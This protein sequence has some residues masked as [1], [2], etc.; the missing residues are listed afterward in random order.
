[1]KK[2]FLT[3]ILTAAAAVLF[4]ADSA[5]KKEDLNNVR[6][7]ARNTCARSFSAKWDETEKAIVF[8]ADF[9]N[10]T[11]N[12][13]CYPTFKLRQ[14]EDISGATAIKYDIK[15]VKDS[16][17]VP[18]SH[19]VML[20]LKGQKIKYLKVENPTEEWKTVTVKFNETPEKL[21][22]AEHINIGM[23]SEEQILKYM[24]RNVELVK[25]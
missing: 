10:R 1:M 20:K 14:G 9:K 15:L 5:P 13:W 19:L 8:T 12:C 11:D 24:I 23:H 22:T 17:P 25:N 21:K 3:L 7:W 16:Y 2:A 4:A 18:G 6:R